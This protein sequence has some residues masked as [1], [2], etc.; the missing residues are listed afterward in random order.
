[1][2][3]VVTVELV[4]G[5]RRRDRRAFAGAGRI[6][7]DRGRAALVAQLVEE[8]AALALGLA[9]VGGEEVG[10]GLGERPAKRSAK[11]LHRRPV[12]RASS[13]TT[14]WT[15]LPPD[16][17]GKLFR[18]MSASRPRRRTAA[19]F[20]SSKS[21]PSSGSRSNTIRSGYL[22]LARPCCP[23]RGIRSCPSARRRAARGRRRRRDNPRYGRPSRSIGTCFTCGAEGAAVVLLEE[24]F[25]RRGPAGQR[26]RVI[27]R[28]AAST[29]HQRRDRRIIIGE[30]ALG[31]AVLGEDDAFADC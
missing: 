30:L 27:G 7:H 15:P 8:D 19:A 13:G 6:R 1:M 2:A 22:D 4:P 29:Q 23:S 25:L 28:F 3:A 5:D 18:P 16:S 10:L 21:R 12:R 17:I 24:A 14:T 20:T 11:S 26:T 9:D 31:E